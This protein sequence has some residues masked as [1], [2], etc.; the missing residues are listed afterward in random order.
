MLWIVSG[1]YLK[2]MSTQREMAQTPIWAGDEMEVITMVA[3]AALAGSQMAG[4]ETGK[5]KVVIMTAMMGAANARRRLARVC[6]EGKAR[7][8]PCR[9]RVEGVRINSGT[10]H[11]RYVTISISEFH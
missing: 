9:R 5:G 3:A 10:K 6:R 2:Q 7:V 4:I 8:N 11:L 1:R